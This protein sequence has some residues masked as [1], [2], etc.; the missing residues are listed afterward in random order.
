MAMNGNELWIGLAVGLLPYRI[1]R[2][3]L[4]RGGRVLEVQALFW[5]L[6]VQR[7]R[8]GR[9]DWKVRVP[10]IERLRDAAWA[11]VTRLR[12]NVGPEV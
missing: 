10:L 4:A 3:C 5:S 12:G 9:C 7:R 2:K 1:E 11:A 8:S 6:A